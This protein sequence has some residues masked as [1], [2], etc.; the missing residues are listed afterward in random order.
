ML[1]KNCL[2]LAIYFS[3]NRIAIKVVPHD[4]TDDISAGERKTSWW[5]AL[6]TEHLPLVRSWV[7][8]PEGRSRNT[9][10]TG[11]AHAV[12]DT[13]WGKYSL[14]WVITTTVPSGTPWGLISP[15]CCS[16]SFPPKM[17]GLGNGTSKSLRV[18]EC[19]LKYLG[20]CIRPLLRAF[21]TQ[22]NLQTF[23]YFTLRTTLCSRKGQVPFYRWWN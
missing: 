15:L 17:R 2:C 22:N 5:L 1:R 19:F 4:V 20:P 7:V 11:G 9:R 13:E 6:R 16:V 12:Q 10:A 23:S 18:Y 21:V 8:C 3:K 14:W